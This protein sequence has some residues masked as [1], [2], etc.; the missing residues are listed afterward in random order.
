MPSKG[1][2]V[3]LFILADD[4]VRLS[5]GGKKKIDTYGTTGHA[6]LR[7]T[8]ESTGKPVE[9]QLEMHD[10]TGPSMCSVFWSLPGYKDMVPIPPEAFALDERNASRSAPKNR[11]PTVG[12]Q[13]EYFEDRGFKNAKA[14]HA[15]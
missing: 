2:K 8:Y 12:V 4:G 3:E 10:V 14:R 9:I 7:H 5:L 1:T 13:L 15:D 11:K 6:V